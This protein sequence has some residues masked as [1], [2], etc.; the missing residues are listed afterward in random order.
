VALLRLLS[1]PASGSRKAVSNSQA[2]SSRAVYK[3][4]RLTRIVAS[5]ATTATTT[6]S[7]GTSAG[8]GAFVL[9]SRLLVPLLGGGRILDD[10]PRGLAGLLIL[11]RIVA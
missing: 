1:R 11:W 6:T 7:T 2:P 10:L 8:A 3:A 4:I 5:K 9:R